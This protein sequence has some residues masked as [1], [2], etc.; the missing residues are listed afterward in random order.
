MTFSEQVVAFLP[1]QRAPD[2]P[3]GEAMCGFLDKLLQEATNAYYAHDAT[4]DP[5]DDNEDETNLLTMVERLRIL[6]EP[7]RL[8]CLTH[9]RSVVEYSLW[10]PGKGGDGAAVSGGAG[11]K[12]QGVDK[13][14]EGDS[15]SVEQDHC[16]WLEGERAAMV[17]RFACSME[18][19]ASG[20][21]L[22]HFYQL[23]FL[24]KSSPTSLAECW[25]RLT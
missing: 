16:A 25:R 19:L 20:V 24:L 18:G 23:K 9:V 22:E 21:S 7:R 2:V 11:E 5:E 15:S 1:H 8:E 14:G 13:L 12:G 17:A 4:Q 10:G 6:L 3:Q